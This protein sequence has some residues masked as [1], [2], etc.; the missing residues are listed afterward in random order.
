[1]D[2][3]MQTVLLEGLII[4]VPK[5]SCSHRQRYSACF[6]PVRSWQMFVFYSHA[7]LPLKTLGLQF[8]GS[9]TR[10]HILLRRLVA[11]VTTSRHS[12]R[13]PGTLRSNRSIPDDPA[14]GPW[15]S[16]YDSGLEMVEVPVPSSDN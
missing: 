2:L 5:H 9:R 1:M 14:A 16:N 13:S 11:V 12:V 6:C 4:V 7:G 15:I 10:R 3:H 8:C